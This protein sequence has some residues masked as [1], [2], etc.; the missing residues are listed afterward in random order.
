MI[1]YIYKIWT[2]AL[3]QFTFLYDNVLYGLM[4]NDLLGIGILLSAFLDEALSVGAGIP[5][6]RVKD[7]KD[8]DS[9]KGDVLSLTL[10]PTKND[11]QTDE[12][13]E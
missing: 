3:S 9:C 4:S 12:K 5:V 7:L 8:P 1:L 11:K 13:T 6:D 2:L 10:S